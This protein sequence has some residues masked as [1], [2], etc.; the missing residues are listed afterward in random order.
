MG[1]SSSKPSAEAPATAVSAPDGTTN[2]VW[3]SWRKPSIAPGAADARR[4]SLVYQ[5]K[6][7]RESGGLSLRGSSARR[8]QKSAHFDTAMIGT[9]TR[10]GIAP[11]PGGRGAK[12]KI[13]Q[14]R[15]L[16]AWPFNG[17]TN[18][19]VFAIFDGHGRNGERVSEYCTQAIPKLLESD[20]ALLK[21]DAET[22][23][24]ISK[25]IIEMDRGLND[26]PSLLRCAQ[27]AGTT[28]T[29]IYLRGDLCWVACSGD[30]RAVLGQRVN[31][32]IQAKD[33]SKDHK[34]DG[35][36]EF[37]RIKAAGGVV[38]PG[39]AGGGPPPSRIWRPPSKGGGC[40]LA[41]SRSIGDLELRDWGCIPN[42]EMQHV[43]LKPT[44]A[45][46]VDGDVFIIVASDGVWEFI[47]S[48]EACR[49]V[50]PMLK[51][52]TEACNKLVREAASRWAYYEGTYRD[53]ITAVVA[54][55][56]FLEEDEVPI[57]APGASP[58][59][60]EKEEDQL[61]TLNAGAGGIT[62]LGAGEMSEKD[63]STISQPP[64]SN[65][66]TAQQMS[67]AERHG[68]KG[69]N[70]ADDVKFIER[71]LSMAQL[72]VDKDDWEKQGEDE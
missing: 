64:T 60:A 53:D 72:D 70:A 25:M 6:E 52:A 38:T 21:N 22:S 48:D 15:G 29:V 34:P 68:A 63:P 16:V 55:L 69:R 61:I 12:A 14:D 17:S 11:L 49:I 59:A 50:E 13:N 62:P 66:K 30:S 44:N 57:A 2:A 3:L 9:C 35:P 26:D 46:K 27:T 65:A 5:S 7:L 33:L 23:N 54:F 20:S 47:D 10:H 56:P 39:G 45:P 8:S 32:H 42:P 31:G 28:S 67:F 71:R 1:C 41:M 40:G 36:G 19:A 51:D 24:H 37:E 4:P 58:A 43:T 18:E